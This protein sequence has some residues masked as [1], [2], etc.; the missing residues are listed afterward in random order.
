MKK[1]FLSV[2]LA[3]AL[4]TF[5]VPALST[6]AIPVVVKQEKVYKKIETSAVPAAILKEITDKYSGYAVN[7]AYAA[8]DT[9]D[10]KIV[11]SKD[12]KVVTVY[13]TAAGEFV[14]EEKKA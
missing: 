9:T 12:A 3:F 4:S 11:L 6:T 5:A 14:K 8:E 13:Y 1:L 10:Y 7:E 2:A